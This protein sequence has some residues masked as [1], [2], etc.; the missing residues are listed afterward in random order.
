MLLPNA[1]FSLKWDEL[2]SRL[3]KPL[4]PHPSQAF[5]SRH[6]WWNKPWASSLAKWGVLVGSQIRENS[7]KQF[8]QERPHI[9][10]GQEVQSFESNNFSPGTTMICSKRGH[11]LIC[12]LQLGIEALIFGTGFQVI[13]LWFASISV[14]RP[15]IGRR[16]RF[17]GSSCL[18]FMGKRF[19]N[20]QRNRWGL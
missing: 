4:K 19:I 3:K 12:E 5:A 8:L 11:I 10:E 15:T 7:L 14:G 1:T 17:K 20:E 16:E 13:Q 18:L 2:S 6:F 9:Q